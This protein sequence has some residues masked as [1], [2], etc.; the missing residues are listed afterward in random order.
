MCL[1]RCQLLVE[2]GDGGGAESAESHM[3]NRAHHRW[4][5]N[6][7]VTSYFFRGMGCMAELHCVL[8]PGSPLGGSLWYDWRLWP[9]LQAAAD[10]V[11]SGAKAPGLLRELCCLRRILSCDTPGIFARSM[12]LCMVDMGRD[13]EIQDPHVS[14]VCVSDLRTDII[15]FL[16]SSF[17]FHIDRLQL[18]QGFTIKILDSSRPSRPQAIKAGARVRVWLA[19]RFGLHVVGQWPVKSVAAGLSCRNKRAI[20]LQYPHSCCLVPGR[21]L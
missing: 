19:G 4:R 20:C 21:D 6:G 10:G 14:R 3:P 5:K 9:Q 7:K 11:S 16:I 12:D 15:G 13:I 18:C 8:P 2:F 1:W 17:G